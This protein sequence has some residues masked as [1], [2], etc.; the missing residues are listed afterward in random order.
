MTAAATPS[1]LF[2]WRTAHP[3][4]FASVF[5]VTNVVLGFQSFCAA[6]CFDGNCLVRLVFPPS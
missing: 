1:T 4:I 3:F 5:F 2:A 6:A